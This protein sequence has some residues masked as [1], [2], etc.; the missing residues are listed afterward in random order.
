MGCPRSAGSVSTTWPT[1]ASMAW[2]RRCR[3]APTR[4][5][6]G[7]DTSVRAS[8]SMLCRCEPSPAMVMRHPDRRD[9][10]PPMPAPVAVSFSASSRWV[11]ARP[12]HGLA[13]RSTARRSGSTACPIARRRSGRW[14]SGRRAAVGAERTGPTDQ[15][16][17]PRGLAKWTVA[18][19]ASDVEPT[20]LRTSRSCWRGAGRRAVRADAEVVEHPDRGTVVHAAERRHSLGSPTVTCRG[21]AP[22]A[23]PGRRGPHGIAPGCD[24]RWA[25]WP[26]GLHERL[27]ARDRGRGRVRRWPWPRSCTVE[28]GAP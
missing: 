3:T 23:E 2:A 7:G 24:G 6:R 22:P 28:T 13:R 8:S 12:A 25:P 1:S 10:S 27:S 18:R 11:T 9:R 15:P 4:F 21:P 26:H 5:D 14:R 19:R 16:S 17:R 20:R